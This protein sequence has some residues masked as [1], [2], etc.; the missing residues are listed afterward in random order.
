MSP[1]MRFSHTPVI[2]CGSSEAGLPGF[3]TFSTAP[4]SGCAAAGWA[5]TAATQSAADSSALLP[6][7]NVTRLFLLDEVERLMSE[8]LERREILRVARDLDVA[9][10]IERDQP[11]DGL[12]SVLVDALVAV[13]RVDPE[14]DQR[15]ADVVAGLDGRRAVAAI[16]AKDVALVLHAVLFAQVRELVRQMVVERAARVGH[17]DRDAELRAVLP[18]RARAVVDRHERCDVAVKHGRRADTDLFRD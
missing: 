10:H 13:A 12:E 6:L 1:T 9:L 3:A 4:G 5:K 7:V 15:G 8:A 2:L 16:V 11:R 17:R 18:R 14:R